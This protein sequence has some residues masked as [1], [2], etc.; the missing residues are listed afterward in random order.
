[1]RSCS[2]VYTVHVSLWIVSCKLK[3]LAGL[4]LISVG[5]LAC[6]RDD[7]AVIHWSAAEEQGKVID[8]SPHSLYLFETTFYLLTCSTSNQTQP[9]CLFS[10]FSIAFLAQANLTSL[11]TLIY[12]LL[13]DVF[14]CVILR[15]L[16]PSPPQTPSSSLPAVPFTTGPTGRHTHNTPRFILGC[17][18]V[19]A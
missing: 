10:L 12:T 18:F 15:I 8:K 1:V 3:Y 2:L 14:C 16:L 4:W 19:S 6:S 13:L 11:I 7:A 17:L 5:S 9:L